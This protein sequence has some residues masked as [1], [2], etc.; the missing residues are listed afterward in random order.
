MGPNG[1]NRAFERAAFSFGSGSTGFF[2][3][4]H[5]RNPTNV[6]KTNT[7]TRMSTNPPE[8]IRFVVPH[9]VSFFGSTVAIASPVE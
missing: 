1:Q 8:K 3:N 6:N 5:M 7:P 4:H 2:S 9:A